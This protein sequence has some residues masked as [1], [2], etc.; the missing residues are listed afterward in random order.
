MLKWALGVKQNHSD[1]RA[2]E[3]R[4]GNSFANC[5]LAIVCVGLLKRDCGQLCGGEVLIE[6]DG[7]GDR[8]DRQVLAKSNDDK[9]VAHAAASHSSSLIAAAITASLDQLR[10]AMSLKP[11]DMTDRYIRGVLSG[12]TRPIFRRPR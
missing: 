1:L 6:G 11:R 10:L 12:T 7:V 8:L 4:D 9:I 3:L 5:E 2:E